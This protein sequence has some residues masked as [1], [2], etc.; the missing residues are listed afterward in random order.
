MSYDRNISMDI[1]GEITDVGAVEELSHYMTDYVQPDYDEGTFKTQKEAAEY[2]LAALREGQTIRV[3][4][5]NT[6]SDLD[7]LTTTCRKYG[8]S[9]RICANRYEDG[10]ASVRT[11]APGFAEER[12]PDVDD[13]YTAVVRKEQL[14]LMLKLPD[15]GYELEAEVRRLESDMLENVPQKVTAPGDVLE[16]AQSLID[17]LGNSPVP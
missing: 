1:L 16:D 2:I 13:D 10:P 6:T 11:W 8:L 14:K 15:P 12:R 9:Y 5:E 7:Y 17:E 3:V 4:S